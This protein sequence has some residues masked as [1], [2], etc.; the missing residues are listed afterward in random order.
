M[1]HLKSSPGGAPEVFHPAK[2]W[3]GIAVSL[4]IFSFEKQEQQKNLQLAQA[5]GK[6]S[7]KTTS[8]LEGSGPGCGSRV[9]AQR[10]FELGR[11]A[12]LCKLL[13]ASEV[14]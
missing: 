6:C 1:P 13:S 7:I 12:A 8:G 14:K 4:L 11:A 10:G 5:T 3:G 2:G 9:C